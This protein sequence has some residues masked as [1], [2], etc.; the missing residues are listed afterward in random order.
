MDGEDEDPDDD[1]GEDNQVENDEQEEEDLLQNLGLVLLLLYSTHLL[2]LLFVVVVLLT[3]FSLVGE[4]AETEED[5]QDGEDEPRYVH[6]VDAGHYQLHKRHKKTK[7]K[8]YVV[9]FV[10]FLG[11]LAIRISH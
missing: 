5:V 2:V 6:D 7:A 1:E 8:E 11:C 3:P 10:A 4:I 9:L